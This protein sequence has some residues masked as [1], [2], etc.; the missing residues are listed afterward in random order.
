M[1][2][3]AIRKITY[4]GEK[5][6]YESPYLEDGIIIIEGENEHG[7]STLMDLIYYGLGG[8]V[9]GFNKGDGHVANKHTE[10]FNDKDNYVELEIEINSKKF[11]LTRTIGENRI[12]VV[13]T[14]ENVEEYDLYRNSNNGNENF[15]DW[16]LNQLNIRVF[17]IVQGTKSFK[18]GFTDLMRLI[19]HDQKTEIDKIYKNPEN[20]NFVSD[21]LEVRKAI[22]EVLIGGGYNEYYYLLG[23]YKVKAKE[24]ERS[25][26]VVEGYDE[27][28]D[29][30]LEGKVENLTYIRND[31]YKKIEQ[32]SNLEKEREIARNE[33]NN[34]SKT[35]KLIEEQRNKIRQYRGVIE[36]YESAR[37]S[38]KG[39]L[40]KILFLIDET[41]NEI[42]EIERIRFVDK[43]LQ[44]FS[45]DTCPYCLRKVERE[46]GKC[47]CGG[48][49]DEEEYERFFY[50]NEEYLQMINVKKKSVQSLSMLLEKKNSRLRNINQVIEKNT[51]A[52]DY[53][54]KYID[55]LS[56]DIISEYNSA[57]VKNIDEKINNL[58]EQILALEQAEELVE[59]KESLLSELIT[60][61]NGL[62]E[63]R[64]L[65]D[66]KLSVAK[67]EMLAK[68][69]DFNEIY[70][71]LMKDT[72]KYCFDAYLGDD[73]MP[74]INGGSY[75]ARSASV[76][77]RLMYFLTLLILSVKQ[78]I[79]YPRFL[80]IDTPNKEGI[81]KDNL[82]KILG[83]LNK[84]YEKQA[85]ENLTF[86]IILTTGIESYPKN[87]DAKVVLILKDDDKLLKEK[88]K[89]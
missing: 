46:K 60:L 2:R 17:D 81:D 61:R 1:G 22:F 5:Y 73:Y 30:I 75:R 7:K 34:A 33:K 12:F 82:I 28:L 6:Y 13:D 62:D 71:E 57:Y 39:S 42:K 37:K 56:K 45:P 86:Q 54:A 85:D 18:L 51:Q 35:W 21:S 88:V 65:V 58:A 76:S 32:K 41:S 3:L 48:A 50:T 87:I 47:I 27:F 10:I 14:N 38:V 8:K 23:K 78:E 40:N 24:Y 59:K 53:T 25:K 80:M 55:D 29:E 49:V 63:L 79:N 89:G 20:D 9:Q 64:I 26:A 36:E 11:T 84:V 74:Y 44:L 67:E 66:N 16:I 68:K 77:K 83:E 69:K 19:Y 72:D 15:S 4:D 52:I 31:K 70:L 43:S